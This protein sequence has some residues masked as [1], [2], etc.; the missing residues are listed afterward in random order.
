MIW[1]QQCKVD[2]SA[3]TGESLT[4]R[5]STDALPAETVLAD[6][7]NMAFMGTTISSGR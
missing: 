4:I 2:E 5:K 1:S 3:L 6:R 7:N